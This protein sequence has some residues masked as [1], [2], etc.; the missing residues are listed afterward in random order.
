[1]GMT[2][3]GKRPSVDDEERITVETFIID[4]SQDVYEK[5]CVLE[6]FFPIRGVIKFNSLQEVQEQVQKDVQASRE[7][8]SEFFV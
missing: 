4:F 1:M 8:L 5:E 3:I 6:V 7:K 2:N